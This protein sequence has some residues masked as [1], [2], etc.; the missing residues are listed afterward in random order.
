YFPFNENHY[1]NIP[2]K[3]SS[4]VYVDVLFSYLGRD[5]DSGKSASVKIGKDDIGEGGI[6]WVGVY[7]QDFVTFNIWADLD[8]KKSLP[9]H[10][11]PKF[12]DNISC[13]QYPFYFLVG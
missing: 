10:I 12:Q 3:L 13:S 11:S 4:S 8:S 1:H 5:M 6:V 7:S 2:L 9:S